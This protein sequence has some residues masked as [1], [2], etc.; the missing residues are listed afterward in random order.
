MGYKYRHVFLSEHDDLGSRIDSTS[1]LSQ[2]DLRLRLRI[3]WD[4]DPVDHG[5]DQRLRGHPTPRPCGYHADFDICLLFDTLVN[6]FS[7]RVGW[8]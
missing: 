3:R 6:P 4:G 8:N 2:R 5:L 7:L 1:G